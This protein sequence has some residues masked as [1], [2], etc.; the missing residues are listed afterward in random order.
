MNNINISKSELGKELNIVLKKGQQYNLVITSDKQSNNTFQVRAIDRY[1]NPLEGVTLVLKDNDLTQQ[2]DTESDG[3]VQFN[4]VASASPSLE[5]ADISQLRQILLEQQSINPISEL[6]PLPHGTILTTSA[7]TGST[8][9]KSGQLNQL[10][11]ISNVVQVRLVGMFFDNAK[12][13]LLP[14]AMNG[15]KRI[16]EI[17]NTF[18]D[19]NIL[20][21]GHTDTKHTDTAAKSGEQFNR[22]LSLE[23]AQSIADYLKDQLDNWYSWYDA[24]YPKNWGTTEDKYMLQALGYYQKKQTL[25]TSITQYQQVRNLQKTG[26]INKE[27]RKSLIKDYMEIDNTS[28]PATATVTTH[29]CGPYFPDKPTGPNESVPE[30]RRVEIFIFDGPIV[31]PPPGEYSDADSP[32]YTIWKNQVTEKIDFTDWTEEKWAEEHPGMIFDVKSGA[33]ADGNPGSVESEPDD[34]FKNHTFGDEF[35]FWNYSMNEDEPRD[36]HLSAL[37]VINSEWKD[38]MAKRPFLRIHLEGDQSSTESNGLNTARAEILN[39]LF[40]AAGIDASRID[41]GPGPAVHFANETEGQPRNAE[42]M[43]RNRRTEAY[44]YPVIV[45]S[46]NASAEHFSN[47]TAV[48]FTNRPVDVNIFD[49]NEKI[50]LTPNPSPMSGDKKWVSMH[51]TADFKEKKP[52]IIYAWT[53]FLLSSEWTGEYNSI[54]GN[55]TSLKKLDYSYDKYLGTRDWGYASLKF[56]YENQ[57]DN[58]G[59][60]VRLEQLPADDVRYRLLDD[61]VPDSSSGYRIMMNDKPA[62]SFLKDYPDPTDPTVTMTLKKT[63]WKMN[64]LVVLVQAEESGNSII[65]HPMHHN[66]WSIDVTAEPDPNGKWDRSN[67][68]NI[69]YGS[70]WNKGLPTT[71]SAT[72]IQQ[73][74]SKPTARFMSRRREM[75]IESEFEGKPARPFLL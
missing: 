11:F 5:V 39:N 7:I 29:G 70:T 26:T 28:L 10:I 36:E 18:P 6:P 8:T 24:F 14:K 59:K 63:W 22:E 40:I 75:Q 65:Y 21:V 19:A 66:T 41:I 53:Q 57:L 68:G 35:V 37:D 13:F 9:L 56:V 74:V 2:A 20:I 46:T 16:V 33:S 4:N 42:N 44:L 38:K 61:T 48:A 12:C 17:Y 32:G 60:A 67:A 64:F 69:V 45:T 72:Q 58:T 34:P 55:A 54:Q 31:P 1:G 43:A 3:T 50:I 47:C 49:D 62:A 27:T 23:R 73:M 51:A 15:I 30:N 52:G 71:V 25:N